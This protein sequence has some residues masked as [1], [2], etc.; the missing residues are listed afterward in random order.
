MN[1][2]SSRTDIE[3]YVVNA[4]P[5]N[6]LDVD[7]GFEAAATAIQRADHPAYGTDWAGWLGENA[8]CLALASVGCVDGVMYS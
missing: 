1:I 4:N 7:G 3:T 5:G 8:E 6:V 2:I